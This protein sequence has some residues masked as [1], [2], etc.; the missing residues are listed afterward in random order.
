MDKF[1]KILEKYWGY[2][3]FRPLQKEIIE[4][5]YG[6]QDTL[7]LLPTGGG[8]S[9]TYQ[10]PA[11]AM[12]GI[13]IVVT[14]LI[15]LMKDQ[16]DFLRS[17]GIRALCVHSGMS[18][19]TIDIT[20]D[21]AVYGNYKF[22]YIS[23]ERVRTAIF[24]D[25]YARMNVSFV[26]IDEA[27]C[28]SQWGYDFRRSYLTLSDLRTAHPDINFLAVT[29]SA[30]E[31]VCQDIAAKLELYK[32]KVFKKSFARESLSY[33]VRYTSDKMNHLVKVLDSIQ[34]VGIVYCTLRK[35]C[36]NIALYLSEK[37]YSA[38][39]YHGGMS[40]QMRTKVQEDWI[41][42][43]S[44]II[45][46]T[47][48]FGMGI[49]KSN[50]RFVVHYSSPESIES[51]YQEAGRAGRDGM[52]SYAV[53]LYEQKNRQSAMQHLAT[54]YPSIDKIK[55]IYHQLFNY[56]N[57]GIGEGKGDMADIDIMEF[58]I[59]YHQFSAVV[60]SAIEILQRNDYLIYIEASDNPP[61]VMITVARDQLYNIQIK[62][63]HLNEFIQLI[64]RLYSGVFSN[65]VKIDVAYITAVSG[66]KSEYINECF[67]ALGRLRIIN[68]IPAKRNPIIFLNEE[69][70]SESNIR[71]APETYILRKEQSE[72]RLKKMFEY[73]DRRDICRSV[74]I[75]KYF[76][77]SDVANCGKCDFCRD[78]KNLL[79]NSDRVAKLLRGEKLD[80]YQIVSRTNIPQDEVKNILEN[81]LK[82]SL[83]TLSSGFYYSLKV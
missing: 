78:S 83:L 25:R 73:I 38:A 23:P 10:I 68:Y 50:V 2:T 21:N 80:F 6:G 46:A 36:D 7:A 31:A 79:S 14:P 17:K 54:R 24:R 55:Q 40:Y 8:K 4:S 60:I 77:E 66:Y 57:I 19:R 18:N 59:K 20:L 47:N 64:M 37:G 82:K 61:R 58:C 30:T 43:R 45:V 32:P 1:E 56:F 48:A 51:Y 3:S 69:R 74:M 26:A 44:K 29:A 41:A 52:L 62:E 39:S 27:H 75:Q 71:I 15:S 67:M 63:R 42:E 72:E 12:E 22:L 53:L 5:L 34:G 70:L 28:I 49:D 81:M 65:F 16:V 35:D 76:G 33:I 9:V 11:M 13:C